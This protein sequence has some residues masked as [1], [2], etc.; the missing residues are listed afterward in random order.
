MTWWSDVVARDAC[1]VANGFRRSPPA[2]GAVGATVVGME[3]LGDR[4]WRSQVTCWWGSPAGWS[5]PPGRPPPPPLF[6]PSRCLPLDNYS[7]EVRSCYFA[8]G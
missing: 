8:E 2:R 5:A 6:D 4:L 3:H 1:R 7:G